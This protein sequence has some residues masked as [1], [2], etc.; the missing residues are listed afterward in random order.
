MAAA[1]PSRPYDAYETGLT[2][3]AA[4]RHAEA[5][6][7]FEDALSS[8]PEDSRILFALGNTA[9]A[10][11]LGAA[12]ENFYRR[13]LAR[14]PDRLEAL[15]NLANLL[16]EMGRTVE[17]IDL[18]KPNIEARPE[19]PE[20]WLTLGSACREAGDAERAAVFY[21]EALRL[22]PDYGAALG[23]LADIIADDGNIPEALAL[24]DTLL[25]AAPHNAQARLNR[26]ILFLASGEL[27]RGWRDYEYRLKLGKALRYD[28]GLA[29][30]NG[31]KWRKGARLLVTVEQGLGDQI[32]FAS[33]MPQ[34]L[35]IAARHD[36]E[37]LLEA[38]PRLVPVFARSFP[39][40]SVHPCTIE[41]CGG[42]KTARYQWLAEAGGADMAIAQAS[43]PGYLRATLDEFPEEKAF[44]LADSNEKNFWRNWL[45]TIGAGPYVGLCWRSGKSGGLRS[46]QYAPLEEWADFARDCPGTLICTQY[47]AG[48]EE[49]SELSKL[50]GRKI[51]LPPRLD[52]K[53]EIDR[54]LALLSS[55][56][57]VVSAPT[58]V[59]WMSAAVGVPTYKILYNNSWTALGRDYEPFAPACRCV[60]PKRRGD[61]AECFAQVLEVLQ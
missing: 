35:G 34:L 60:M 5:I 50:S 27:K 7:C 53:Q 24:Y 14:E 54:T 22:K 37:V 23:N 12:A 36:G 61:W 52:Q 47:D 20:L 11:G 16:R 9:R 13:V 51:H 55:L 46:L 29:E 48:G 49:L 30:W 43:L 44:L 1:L 57:A 28:H 31:R 15:V 10:I 33:V 18:L 17:A 42:V 3:A 25:K 39:L 58:A 8:A 26:A 56:D 19:I 41:G 4:G 59:S 45:G 6:S 21:R 38:E 2:L 40:A 32:A